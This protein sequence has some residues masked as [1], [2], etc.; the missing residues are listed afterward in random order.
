MP[1][2]SSQNRCRAERGAVRSAKMRRSARVSHMLR[3][4]SSTSAGIGAPHSSAARDST[5][6]S[7]SPF[8]REL[9]DIVGGARFDPHYS[10]PSLTGSDE[11]RYLAALDGDGLDRVARVQVTLYSQSIPPFY[12]QQRFNDA[13][14][15]PAA[16]DD[17]QR[18][19]YMTSHLN[20]D[21]ATDEAGERPMQDWK[22][23]IAR[24]SRDLR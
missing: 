10:D 23:I 16:Q 2:R 8:I 17:I 4:A 3:S 14:R 7:P 6:R 20:V 19:Y 12:L 9:A 1:V 22:L 11:I 21:G 13:H 18:L 5:A 24:A 15:G